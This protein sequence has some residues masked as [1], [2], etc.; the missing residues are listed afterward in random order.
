[1]LSRLHEP[2]W[3]LCTDPVHVTIEQLDYCPVSCQLALESPIQARAPACVTGTSEQQPYRSLLRTITS[4]PLAACRFVPLFTLQQ[5][6]KS[7]PK[8]PSSQPIPSIAAPY[9]QVTSSL[10]QLQPLY[11]QAA[12]RVCKIPSLSCLTSTASLFRPAPAAKDQRL[13]PYRRHTPTLLPGFTLVSR[14]LQQA[15]SL[16]LIKGHKTLREGAGHFGVRKK[17]K[18]SNFWRE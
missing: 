17:E 16:S 15:M 11:C 7:P 5:V 8:K 10:V 13:V 9:G 4:R 6:G 14:K 12:P 18:V 1:M 3:P 2:A